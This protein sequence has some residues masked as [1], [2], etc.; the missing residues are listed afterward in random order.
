MLNGVETNGN[1]NIQLGITED[2]TA[3][4]KDL[5]NIPH[6]LIAGTTGSGKTAFIQSL[7]V[8][9][10]LQYDHE[11]VRLAIFDSKK[12]NYGIFN[13]SANLLAPVSTDC[14]KAG[15]LISFLNRKANR[16]IEMKQE[17]SLLNEEPEI[18]LI[19]DDYSAL[20]NNKTVSN[21][22]SDLL[23]IG[24]SVKIHCIISTSTPTAKIIPTEL[25]ANIPCRI[26]F[27]TASKA[28]SRIILDTN[29]AETLSAPGEM[30]FK[31]Q[32]ELL[33]CR[34]LYFSDDDMQVIL[35]YRKKKYD[36]DLNASGQQVEKPFAGASVDDESSKTDPLLEDAIDFVLEA[37]F[38][39]ISLLQRKFKLGYGRAARIIDEM[40]ARGIIGARDGSN[41]RKV[42]IT[43]KEKP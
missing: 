8:T 27:S 16:R 11:K 5:A 9:L 34:C 26:A 1:L 32:N 36:E 39:S 30:I 38:A 40:E 4:Y 2:G 3:V 31:W 14:T 21:E 23:K 20:S 7:L 13:G 12:V 43:K 37:G 18:F 10:M 6:M 35:N 25:K 42:L 29:G 24:R 19:I 17:G 33:K 28:D 41:P 15:G 22:L